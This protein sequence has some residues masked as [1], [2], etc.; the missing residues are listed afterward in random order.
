[1]EKTLQRRRLYIIRKEFQLKY[2]GVILGV[3]FLGA[4]ISG[5]TIYHNAWFLLGEKLANVYPQ[6][7][8]VQIFRSVNIRLMLNLF[9]SSIFCIGIGIFASHKIAGP[10]YRMV[11]FLN[12]VT[13]GDYSQRIILRKHDELKDLAEAINNLVDKLE[14]GNKA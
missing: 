13:S 11:K 14:Q 10:I 12:N 3:M 8:L 5:Y 4:V 6:G 7:R 9:F 1:M 2:I